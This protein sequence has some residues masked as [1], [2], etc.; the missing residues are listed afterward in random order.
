MAIIEGIKHCQAEVT[1]V[2]MGETHSGGSMIA[3]YCHNLAVLDSA[4]MMVHHASFGSYGSA[5]N[6][7]THSAFV[8]KRV[9]EIIDE[10][11]EGFLTPEEIQELKKGVELWFDAPEIRARMERR[12]ELLAS[13]DNGET[14]EDNGETQEAN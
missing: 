2:L 5:G 3:M 9:E 6:V 8:V 11:Y 13:K 14:Q 7:K 4:Q 1:G 12:N 10:A